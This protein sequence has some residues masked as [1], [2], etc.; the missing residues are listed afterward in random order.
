MIDQVRPA[1]LQAWI[2]SQPSGSKPVVLDVREPW[3][4]QS[5]W[6]SP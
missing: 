1:D 6:R 2:Q 4:L 5:W 3:E